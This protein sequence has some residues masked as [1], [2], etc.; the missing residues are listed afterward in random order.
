VLD[1]GSAFELLR[2]SP[3]AGALHA[4]RD[5]SAGAV[6]ERIVVAFDRDCIN[7][8]EGRVVFFEIRSDRRRSLRNGCQTHRRTTIVDT[9]IESD[10]YAK[11]RARK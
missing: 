6:T 1:D 9:E 4:D 5:V 11:A 3:P 2:Y 10:P 8:R 7:N